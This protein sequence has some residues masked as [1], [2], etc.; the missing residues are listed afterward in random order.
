MMIVCCRAL[1]ALSGWFHASTANWSLSS[2][3]P[4]TTRIIVERA[5]SLVP[6]ASAM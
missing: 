4:K 2:V 1:N 5:L 6:T 3:S